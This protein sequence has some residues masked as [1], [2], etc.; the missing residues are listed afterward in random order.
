M[1]DHTSFEQGR[2]AEAVLAE[3]Q[4]IASAEDGVW[5]DGRCSGTIYC[6]DRAIYDLIGQAFA[7]FS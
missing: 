1:G 5:A 7:L 2:G 6:G 4:A 3:L